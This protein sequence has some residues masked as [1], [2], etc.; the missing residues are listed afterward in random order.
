MTMASDQIG[1]GDVKAS[2]NMIMILDTTDG[3]F[4]SDQQMKWNLEVRL[5]SI[6]VVMESWPGYAEMQGMRYTHT[7]LI[8]SN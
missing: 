1:E 8:V 4:L 5:V 6:P 3:A 2:I 7:L